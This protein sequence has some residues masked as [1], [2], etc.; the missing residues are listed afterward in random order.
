MRGKKEKRDHGEYEA[1]MI[2]RSLHAVR[3]NDLSSG[4]VEPFL[5]CVSRYSKQSGDEYGISG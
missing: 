3:K 4:V 5:A 2:L 1:C